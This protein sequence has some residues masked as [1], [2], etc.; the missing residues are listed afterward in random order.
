[1]IHIPIF[2]SILKWVGFAFGALSPP[3]TAF[4]IHRARHGGI[5][6]IV[7]DNAGIVLGVKS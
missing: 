2:D 4:R 5:P 6:G 7:V 1:M 3:F